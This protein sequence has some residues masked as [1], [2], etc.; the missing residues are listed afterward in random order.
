MLRWALATFVKGMKI[1]L[2]K[3]W[4]SILAER[5]VLKRR[6]DDGMV[7]L[8]WIMMDMGL[9]HEWRVPPLS[10]THPTTLNPTLSHNMYQNLTNNTQQHRYHYQY[11]S[12]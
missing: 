12:K 1:R 3:N 11:H 7:N 5:E 6:I 8:W 10:P 4:L 9:W 2:R